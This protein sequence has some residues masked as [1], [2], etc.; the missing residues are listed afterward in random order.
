MGNTA[1]TLLTVAGYFLLVA[2]GA[3]LGSRRAVR[4]HPVPWLSPLQTVLLLAIILALGIQLGANEEVAASLYTIGISALVIAVSAMTGSILL[5]LCLRIFVLHLDRIALPVGTKQE[6][7][8][9]E[10]PP[11]DG[12]L[13]GMITAAVI[14]GFVLGRW[15]LPAEAAPLCARIVSLGL[16]AM[17][18]LVGLDLGRQG[19]TVSSI[20]SAGIGALLIPAAVVLGSLLFGAL[21]GSFLPFLPRETAAAAAGMGWYSLAPTLLAPYSLKL[22]AVAFLANVLREILSILL[23]PTIARRL[24][25]LEC[26]SA[27]GATAMDTVLPVIVRATSRRMTVYAFAS[28]LICSLLVP[29]LVPL[30]AGI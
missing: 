30:L 28:G 3:V 11:A 1:S 15:L 29:L 6:Q 9:A 2:L 12:S 13:T 4:S 7:P 16:D 19:E 5:L 20:R 21:A 26:V 14:L 24:G 27:A 23:I 8:S 17:L 25:Y 22:S 18:L 10:D